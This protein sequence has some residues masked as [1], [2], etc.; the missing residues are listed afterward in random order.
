MYF[1][2]IWKTLHNPDR[3][4]SLTEKKKERVNKI[5]PCSYRIHRETKMATKQVFPHL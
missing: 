3:H 5:D 1:N 2:L 4:C